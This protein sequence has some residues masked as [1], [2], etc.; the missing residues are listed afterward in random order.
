M[1]VLYKRLLTKSG[2]E[3]DVIYV[4]GICVITYNHL[5]DTYLFSP[6]ESWLRKYEKARG[7]FEKEI[8]VDYRKIL[9]L[10]EI[11]KLYID[12]RGKLHSIEDIEFKNLF[13]SL[14]KHIFQLE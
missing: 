8:E 5:L 2:G 7:K 1:K 4:P 13:N 14:V 11:G 9:R 10:V 6:K 12:P 3:Q